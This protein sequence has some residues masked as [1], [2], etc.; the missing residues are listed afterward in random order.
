MTSCHQPRAPPLQAV[1]ARTCSPSHPQ[2]P[3]GAVCRGSGKVVK[4]AQKCQQMR[5]ALPASSVHPSQCHWPGAKALG[6]DSWQVLSQASLHEVHL[7]YGL[8]CQCAARGSGSRERG[9]GEVPGFRL[10]EKRAAL[11]FLGGPSYQSSHDPNETAPS[12]SG[13][14]GLQDGGFSGYGKPS[15][16]PGPGQFQ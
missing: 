2:D 9:R 6:G 14:R 13:L 11:L 8:R 4:P 7:L 3:L 10:G 12:T 5:W 15:H 16:P 1:P